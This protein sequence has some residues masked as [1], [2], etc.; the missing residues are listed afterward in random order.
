[1]D[2]YLSKIESIINKFFK[3]IEVWNNEIKSVNSIDTTFLITKK[4]FIIIGLNSINES[5]LENIIFCFYKNYF[6]LLLEETNYGNY[7]NYEKHKI[8]QIIK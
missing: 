5:L 2:N 8:E 7:I 3:G 4:N 1:M 6:E